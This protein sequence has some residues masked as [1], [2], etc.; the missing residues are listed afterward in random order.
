MYSK[1][2]NFSECCWENYG[3]LRIFLIT[4][5]FWTITTCVIATV[6]GTWDT[7]FVYPEEEYTEIQTEA[8]RII[9]N[10]SFETTY[11]LQITNYSNRDHSLSFDIRGSNNSLLTVNVSNYGLENEEVSY[12]RFTKTPTTHILLELLAVIL[13]I[14]LL[15]FVSMLAILIMISFIWFIAFIIHK[16]IEFS[17]NSKN[18]K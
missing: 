1:I 17:N 3:L 14:V 2:K 5:A 9:S 6:Q 11:E 4:F 10:K 15:A 7:M 18:K 13:L 8:D 12:K 16:I